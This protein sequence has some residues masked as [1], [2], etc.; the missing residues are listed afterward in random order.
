MPQPDNQERFE[1]TEREK[2]L[3]MVVA[4]IIAEFKE[5]R[6]VDGSLDIEILHRIIN[7][8]ITVLP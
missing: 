7:K 5:E 3:I 8:S 6:L 1:V 4:H 2:Y